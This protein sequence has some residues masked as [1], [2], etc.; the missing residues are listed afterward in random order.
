VSGTAS[1][2]NATNPKTVTATC[3]SGKVLGGGFVALAPG[4]GV[5]EVTVTASYPSSDT[6]WT[7]TA[8][9]DNGSDVG[10][11]SLQAYAICADVSN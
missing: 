7:V 1:A 2:S 5:A 10:N 8:S 6:V 3:T 4:G 9:E 11:W